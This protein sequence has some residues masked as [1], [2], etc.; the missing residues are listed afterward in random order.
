MTTPKA[1]GGSYGHGSTT[2]SSFDRKCQKRTGGLR[3]RSR[4]RSPSPDGSERRHSRVGDAVTRRGGKV[5]AVGAG[6]HLSPRA[7]K[8]LAKFEMSSLASLVRHSTTKELIKR[9]NQRRRRSRSPNP[10]RMK[11][12]RSKS[13]R[14]RRETEK[15]KSGEKS[16]SSARSPI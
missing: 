14:G 4:S 1:T 8:E 12:R 5:V 13:P 3:S 11:G 7:G 10:S 2:V 16:S 6:A 9:K 15:T